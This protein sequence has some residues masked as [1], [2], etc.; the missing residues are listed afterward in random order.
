MTVSH[1]FAV[2][3]GIMTGV[4]IAIGLLGWWLQRVQ[5]KRNPPVETQ[6]QALK[7][8]LRDSERAMEIQARDC[9]ARIERLQGVVDTLVA[10]LAEQQQRIRLLE[11]DSMEHP[12]AVGAP[13]PRTLLVVLG[14]D[15]DL[16][17]DLAALRGVPG[18]RVSRIMPATF[19]ELKRTME[20][21]RRTHQEIL[22]VHM[23]VHACTDGIQLDRRVSAVEL[24]EVLRGVQVLCIMGCKSAAV[25]DLLTVVPHVVAFREE[26]PHDEAWQFSVLFWRAVADGPSVDGAFRRAVERGPTGI[27]EY[28]ELLQ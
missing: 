28:A 12:I 8:M 20:R 15:P 16:K 23:A 13:A 7:R 27:G 18:L 6:E 17:V 25:A 19:D 14:D 9:K 22:L 1:E 10:Q 4:G 21:A 24:S 5:E 2:V 11:L 3:F 26:V